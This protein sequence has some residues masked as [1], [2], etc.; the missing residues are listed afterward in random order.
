MDHGHQGDGRPPDDPLAAGASHS[1]NPR[2]ATLLRVGIAAVLVLLCGVLAG[3]GAVRAA[4]E[5]QA[6]TRAAKHYTP[7][8]FPTP[9]APAPVIWV[10][11]DDT[12]ADTGSKLL[13]TQRWPA[14]VADALHVRIDTRASVGAGYIRQGQSARTFGQQAAL[15]PRYADI[16]LFFG[17]SS[18]L[19]APLGDLQR[20]A[21]RAYDAAR[22]AAPNARIVVIGPALRGVGTAQ[23]LAQVEAV[24]QRA[25]AAAHAP[26]V[27]PLKE[28]W[29]G[30][31]SNAPIHGDSLTTDNERALAK[32]VEAVLRPFLPH[33]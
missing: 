29:I 30:T 1:P 12:T 32:H 23:R 15:A 16:V 3:I 14:L 11:S 21:G 17:G 28:Q 13:A 25:A 4:D 24:L 22:A 19:S 31:S 18:E 27:D 33:A 9:T 7:P 20:N 5:S 26:W 10:V 8:P 2:S 6:A